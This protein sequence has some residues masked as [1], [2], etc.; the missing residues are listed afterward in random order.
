MTV[1]LVENEIFS[2]DYVCICFCLD[3][4]EI[5]IITL[6]HEQQGKLL[7]GIENRSLHVCFFA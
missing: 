6:I 7:V 3:R 4:E 5:R 2:D 1:Y